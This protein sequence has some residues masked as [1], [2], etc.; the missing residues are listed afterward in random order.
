MCVIICVSLSR[1]ISGDCLCSIHEYVRIDMYI[2]KIHI[3]TYQYIYICIHVCHSL[4]GQISGDYPFSI[5]VCIRVDTYIMKIHLQISVY[6]C[7]HVCH[8]IW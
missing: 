1:R 6:V 4:P 3:Y 5:R 8:Y 2:T 7:V